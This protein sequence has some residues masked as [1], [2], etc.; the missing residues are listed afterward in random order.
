MD[1]EAYITFLIYPTFA[2]LFI[3]TPTIF[4][5]TLLRLFDRA[6]HG[7]ELASQGLTWVLYSAVRVLAMTLG[8]VMLLFALRLVLVAMN[9]FI[10][11][12]RVV[13]NG[14]GGLISCLFF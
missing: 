4:A 9:S 7:V 10:S 6:A 12:I 3:A 5:F 2:N 8:V 1:P 14:E 13:W 11:S